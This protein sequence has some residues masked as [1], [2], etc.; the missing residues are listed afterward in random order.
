M[1]PVYVTITNTGS[2]SADGA[3]IELIDEN[4]TVRAVEEL[5]QTMDVNS[6]LQVVVQADLPEEPVDLTVRISARDSYRSGDVDGNDIVDA[7]D[8]LLVLQRVAQLVVLTEDQFQRADMD[9]NG[10]LNAADA[11]EILKI[12]ANL[13]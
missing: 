9:G 6:E 2:E 8:A 5:T 11:L 10:L 7:A 1:V 13:S 12:A 4:G 3:I